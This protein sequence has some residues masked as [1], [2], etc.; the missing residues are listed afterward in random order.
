MRA[1]DARG[2]P[3]RLPVSAAARVLPLAWRIRGHVRRRLN[4]RLPFPVPGNRKHSAARRR[5]KPPAH[6]PP[7]ALEALEE[8]TVPSAMPGALSAISALLPSEPAITAPLAPGEASAGGALHMPGGIPAQISSSH[9]LQAPLPAASKVL[10]ALASIPGQ[11]SNRHP[12][13]A[14]LPAGSKVLSMAASIP[15]Q[16]SSSHSLQAPLP[17]ASKVL[18]TLASDLRQR[19]GPLSGITSTALRGTVQQLAKAVQVAGG[20]ADRTFAQPL[21]LTSSGTAAPIEILLGNR[22]SDPSAI[23]SSLSTLVGTATANTAQQLNRVV[24]SVTGD[25]NNAAGSLQTLSRIQSGTTATTTGDATAQLASMMT[26]VASSVNTLL[27][28]LNALAGVLPDL[29]SLAVSHARQFLDAALMDITDSLGA[30]SGSLDTIAAQLAGVIG[31]LPG[32]GPLASAPDDRSASPPSSSSIGG[33]LT[34]ASDILSAMANLL[35]TLAGSLS[36]A[37]ASATAAASASSSSAV[38]A[39]QVIDTLFRGVA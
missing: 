27:G 8:L 24:T 38:G 31:S 7:L 23:P 5:N 17:T 16:V 35:S 3:L 37:L 36:S 15:A 12:L 25:P 6:R 9:S 20:A 10:S 34:E 30:I 14:P 33:E 26:D 22:A 39:R 13:Q 1:G 28:S 11:V 18:S 21:S 29:M 32:D 2:W 4:I 19:A